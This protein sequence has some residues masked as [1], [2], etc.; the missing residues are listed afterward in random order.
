MALVNNSHQKCRYARA[1]HGFTLIEVLVVVTLIG[2][3]AS[4][5][6]PSLRDFLLR[7]TATSLSNEFYVG[8]TQ[9]RTEAITRNTCVS[10]CQSTSTQN[11]ISGGALSCT[12]TGTNWLR[13]WIIVTNPTCDSSD[14]NPVGLANAIVIK[15]TQPPAGSDFETVD[16]SGGSIGRRIM[17]DSRGL[18]QGVTNTANLTLGPTSASEPDKFRRQICISGGGRVTVRAYVGGACS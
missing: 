2:I 13:G 18:L 1:I 5:A 15:V 12:T 3:I 10:M 17:F 6:V 14:T 8:V 9:T 4:L 16:G 11:A 7:N